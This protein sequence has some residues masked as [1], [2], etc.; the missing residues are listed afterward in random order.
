EFLL[1]FNDEVD[2]APVVLGNLIF[3]EVVFENSGRGPIRHEAASDTLW[4]KD[5]TAYRMESFRLDGSVGVFRLEDATLFQLDASGNPAVDIRSDDYAKIEIE[6]ALIDVAGEGAIDIPVGAG[7]E[8]ISI[9]FT[10]VWRSG[11]GE[12]FPGDE[13]VAGDAFANGTGNGEAN[14]LWQ[15]PVNGDFDIKLAPGEGSDAL[16]GG[17]ESGGLVGDG[18]WDLWTDASSVTLQVGGPPLAVVVNQLGEIPGSG[19]EIELF[20]Q[21]V[22][23]VSEP[24]R[25]DV[26]MRIVTPA[27]TDEPLVDRATITAAGDDFDGSLVRPNTSLVLDRLILDGAGNA[28]EIVRYDADDDGVLEITNSDL[29]NSGEDEDLLRLDDEI[30]SVLI[31]NVIIANAGRRPI[32]FRGDLDLGSFTMRNSTVY[33]S[34][35]RIRLDA[36]PETFVMER[37][38]I[39]DIGGSS[40]IDFNVAFPNATFTDVLIVDPDGVDSTDDAEN[41]FTVTFTNVDAEADAI[42]GAFG[43]A[44][45]AAASNFSESPNFR[46]FNGRDFAIEI[47]TQSATGASDGGPVGDPRWGTYNAVANEDDATVPVAFALSAAYPNPFAAATTFDLALPEAADVQVAVYDV[48]GRQVLARPSTALPAGTA[49]VQLDGTALAAGVYVVRVT[50]ASAATTHTATARVVVVR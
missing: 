1:R 41:N 16:I 28:Q 6:D 14:P 31:D 47:M 22:F 46:D 32:A 24:L 36:A 34:A 44:F 7:S 10:Y 3:D 37:V 33:E 20:P 18:R 48:T 13:N 9:D 45:A 43:D 40:A 12:P 5:V 26:P 11:D 35:D 27:T 50:A 39:V 23:L 25:N 2:G 21:D 49:T 17:A 30:A 19:F 42:D 15:D 4:F 8:G 38:T 29:L